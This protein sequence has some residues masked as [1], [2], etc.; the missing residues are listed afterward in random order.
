MRARIFKVAAAFVG[1]LFFDCL[2]VS[3]H[4][5]APSWDTQVL[6]PVVNANLSINDILTS[7][8]LKSNPDSSVSL[9]YTDSLYGLNLDTLLKIPDT[10]LV[11]DTATPISYTFNPGQIMFF[12]SPYPAT[13]LYPIGS[14][15]LVQ[16]IIQS[17]YLVYTLTNPLSQPVD[18]Y[19]KVFNI[20]LN[21]TDTL[22]IKTV[23]APKTTLTDSINLS[24]YNI[25]FTGP[26]HNG[27]NDISSGIQ[28]HLDPNAS[29]LA[30]KASQKL[31][32]A[33]ITFRNVVPHYAKGYFGTT[34]KTFGPQSVNFPVFSKIIAG[35][36]NL[37]NVS[38]N[39]AIKNGFGVDASLFL[40]ELYSYNSHTGDTI[41]LSAPGVGIINSTIHVNRATATNNPASPVDPSLLNFAINPSNSNILQW[42][43]NIPTAIGYKLQVITDPLGNVS[44]SNDF[45]Y[46]GYGINAN[47]NVTIPLSLIA[48]NLTLVDTLAVNFAGSG[49]AASKH[50]KSGT[51]TLYAT[52]GFPFSAGIQLYLLN[53]NNM[54]YDSV[55]VPAQ[56]IIA[57]A[58]VNANTG[59]VISP[60][61]SVLTISLD[62]AHTQ[63]LFNTKNI[64]LEA[65]FNMGNPPS[66]YLKIYNYYQLGVKM[67]ANFDYEI[68]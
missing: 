49:D 50:V 67:V 52:N 57:S 64:M 44:G 20:I 39:L 42:L 23:V 38:V 13:T 48:D 55:C 11:Y 17:G 60:K 56:S 53:K 10:V 36:L 9:V 61:S 2:F 31:V 24:G 1:L 46:Y 47:I 43:D 21:N 62:A 29:P 3:C 32:D 4:K 15:Q 7:N 34:T 12:S 65:R 16:G 51:L 27:Y 63:E 54:V 6:A 66:T 18:Y 25:D 5:T 37:Q 19:Y 28:V 68:N 14:V 45:A 26:T 41:K 59:I 8:Y 30:V 22:E 33:D 35:K 40:S 58:P